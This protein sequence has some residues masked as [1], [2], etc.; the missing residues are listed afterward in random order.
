MKAIF[1]ASSPIDQILANK[2][3]SKV[4]DKSS[5]EDAYTKEVAKISKA[6]CTNPT[7]LLIALLYLERIRMKN[8]SYLRTVSHLELFVVSLVSQ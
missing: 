7:S 4:L 3:N 2:G 5:I 6:I 8:P 1:S